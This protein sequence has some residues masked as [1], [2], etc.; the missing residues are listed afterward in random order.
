MAALA[1]FLVAAHPSMPLQA[2]GLENEKAIETIVDAPVATE[3][4]TVAEE[5]GRIAEAIESSREHA[6]EIRKRIS[7]DKL[8][9][10]FVPELAEDSSPLG[11]AIEDND[12]AIKELRIA[13][14]GSAMFYHAIDSRSVL[15]RDVVAVEF[16]E[17]N[18]VTVFAAS[19]D[20][21]N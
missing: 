21:E 11:K 15:L 20:P 16:G 3:E 14:E 7:I 1:A 12:E 17:G 5:E 13:L 18:D 2:Q 8:D 4:K 6:A 10:V 19:A 9:I